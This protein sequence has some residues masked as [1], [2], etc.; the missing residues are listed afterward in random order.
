MILLR[1]LF[2][3]LAEKC[4]SPVAVEIRELREESAALG[5]TNVLLVRRVQELE[6]AGDD[7][8]R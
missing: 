4:G 3:W 8:G 7:D 5:M 2:L 6:R 1:L